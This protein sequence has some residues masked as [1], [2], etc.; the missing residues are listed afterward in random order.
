MSPRNDD[1]DEDNGN[2]ATRQNTYDDQD[3]E[4][5]Y[6]T[7]SPPVPT[8]KNKD[9]KQ[10]SNVRRSPFDETN[11]QQPPVFSDND[12]LNQL[13]IDDNDGQSRQS[14]RKQPTPKQTGLISYRNKAFCCYFLLLLLI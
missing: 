2:G 12:E 5:A 1:N 6:R 10:K 7:A 8:I 4:P 13:P 14:H 11:Q 3:Q 9:K